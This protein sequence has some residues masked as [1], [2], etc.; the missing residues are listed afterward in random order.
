MRRRVG[1]ARVWKVS[2]C[3]SMYIN[4]NVYTGR[5]KPF[6]MR[7]SDPSFCAHFAGHS[8]PH[9]GLPAPDP[10]D[11]KFNSRP[12]APTNTGRTACI[13]ETP[14]TRAGPNCCCPARRTK[15]GNLLTSNSEITGR[16]LELMA[17][18]ACL[19]TDYFAPQFEAATGLPPHRY[20]LAR[21]VERESLIA[22][23]QRWPPAP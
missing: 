17:A 23:W 1:S 20:A 14:S 16:I 10:S 13:P 19:T 5:V 22:T 9:R 12:V 3:D 2:S 4:Y 8:P 6:P 21:R 15:L 7:F 18:A 11:K